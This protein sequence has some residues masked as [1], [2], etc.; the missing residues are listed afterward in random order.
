MLL[1]LVIKGLAS[2]KA[3][4]VSAAAGVAASAGVV[5][6]VFS[7]AAT[8][9][10]QAPALSAR[11]AEPWAAWKIEGDFRMGP[12]RAAPPDAVSKGASRAEGRNGQAG[13]TR[14]PEPDLRM[15]LVA[16]TIDYRPGGKVLQGPPMR[17]VIAPA[18]EGN[19]YASTSLAQG[20]WVDFASPSPEVVCT[21][22]TLKRFGRGRI[23]DIGESIKFVGANGTMTARIVGYLD[24]VK[25]PMGFPG[26]FANEAAFKCFSAEKR[27]SI[28]LWRKKVEGSGVLTPT[29]ESVVNSFKGDEQRRMD[30]ARP[31]MFVASILTALALMVNSLLLSVEA[32]R[33]TLAMLRTAG[34]TRMGVVGFVAIEAFLSASAGLF[35]GLLISALSLRIYAASDIS[36]FPMG[37]LYDWRIAAMVAAVALLMVFAAVLFALRSALSVRALDASSV[38]PRS[39][40]SGMAIAFGLG[41]ASFVAVEVWGASLMRGFVPSL[42][43]PDAIVSLLPAGASSFDIEKL[44]GIEG[45]ERISELL[46]LQVEMPPPNGA[47]VPED[48]RSMP[49]ALFLAAEW[50]PEFKFVEG[51]HREAFKAV[52]EGDACVISLMMSRARN[53]HK[54]DRLPLFIA[55][56]TGPKTE[57]SLPIAG[58]VDVNWHMVTSRG[59][60]RGMNGA[61]GMTDGPVFASFD[62]V[63]SLDPRPAAHLRMTHLWV[64]YKK[65]FLSEKGVFP[66]G[67]EIERAIGKALGNPDSF[68]VRLHARDEIADGTLAHGS[69][70]IGQAARVPFVFLAILAIGFVAMLVAEADAARNEY[71]ILRA[72]GATRAQL[73][74]RL[75][76]KAIKTAL[77]GMVGAIPI[78]AFA[79][80]FFAVKTAA[81]WAGMPN[82]FEVPWRIIFE[83]GIGALLFALTVAVPTA[84]VII[85]R[86]TRR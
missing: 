71:A 40:V 15:P 44:R 9:S 8:N 4:F 42:E 38:R 53:L 33:K 25:L 50:L 82:Y 22:S 64:V 66:A 19:P 46:P 31:L 23:P 37:V 35:A 6:F 3:R 84:I 76:A 16:A 36:A 24:E 11:A 72:V 27:G 80:W 52:S 77:W 51:T 81:K 41:F 39:R 47:A 63:E 65:D 75:S 1:K 45:V 62:T 74:R 49:N 70:L 85:G 79:G 59:L 34:L 10:A 68:T 14:I 58:V 61:S 5:F 67:R 55:G 26:V 20:R 21:R 13:E 56:R 57:V 30:Y 7:L 48:A 86:A 2:G 73:A 54:G 32:N 12:R 43:W 69:D 83:G 60:V 78:G 28:S 17:A 18:P 29:S